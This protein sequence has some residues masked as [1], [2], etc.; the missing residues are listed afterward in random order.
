[1]DVFPAMQASMGRW[2]YYLLRMNMAE[3]SRNIRFG[4]DIH[5]NKTLSAAIQREL[6]E[7]RST[8]EI[9]S[10]LARQPDRFFNSLVV[11]AIGGSPTW[12]PVTME[13][14][15][16][17]ELFRDDTR[18][19]DT[20]GV[21]RFD[22]EQQYYALD[23]QHRLKGIQV[24]LDPSEDAHANCPE[25]FAKEEISVICV[26]P[27][28]VETEDDFLIR[29]RRLFANLNR[30]AKPMSF[31]NTIMMDEDDMLAIVTRRMVSDHSF[32]QAP[33]PQMESTR[34]RMRKGK[35][36][37]A[38]STYVCTLEG[39]YSMN[40]GLLRSTSR[41]NDGWGASGEPFK[42]FL[43]FRPDEETIDNFYQE[44]EMYWD[45]LIKEI[46]LLENPNPANMR[47]ASAPR[48]SELEDPE[49]PQD[50]ALFRPICQELLISVAR[51]LLNWRQDD[52]ENPTKAS[53]R[54]ALTGLGS[55]VWDGHSAPWRHL[56]FIPTN[57]EHTSWKMASEERKDR[58]S[59]TSRIL[60][61]QIGLDEL[62]DED[63]EEL[64][65]EWKLMLVGIA[66]EADVEALWVEIE[67]GCI[68]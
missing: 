41:E 51:G 36:L 58:M 8:K 68:R 21:L 44:L 46:P 61:W 48:A 25:H 19:A 11:A 50:C 38:N 63:I 39:L 7:S 27:E 32:F 42:S 55:L 4:H 23:G 14:D 2:T 45:G 10:Y 33:G 3:L 54:T 52:P 29:Y 18:L 22:G 34:I 1:M 13:A 64:K 30:Y 37:P 49:D 67:D 26:V 62:L 17:F 53:I 40:L 60:K 31:F 59:L 9:A 56:L 43:T 57:E 16:R 66:N 65:V 5:E 6:D 35:N 28:E 15:D 20:F 12:Y 47:N 24:L